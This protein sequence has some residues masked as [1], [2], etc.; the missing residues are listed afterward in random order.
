MANQ[1]HSGWLPAT[2]VDVW[3]PVYNASATLGCALESLLR[4][5]HYVM[6]II[7]VDDGSDDDTAEILARLAEEMKALTHLT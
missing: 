2:A 4:Q 3:L 6:R 1:T 7:A 5:T